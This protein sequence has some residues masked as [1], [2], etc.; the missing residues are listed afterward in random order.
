[1]ADGTLNPEYPINQINQKGVFRQDLGDIKTL[2]ESL[3]H[4]GL[5]TPVVATA[6]GDLICGKRRLA[7]AVKLGWE[8]IPVWIPAKVSAALRLH[9]LVDDDATSKPLNAIEQAGLYAEYEALYAE[10]ARLRREATFFKQGN[11]AA[12]KTGKQAKDNGREESSQPF[13]TMTDE[14]P[15]TREQAAIAVT[16]GKSFQRLDQIRELQAL[17]SDKSQHPEVQHAAVE[18]VCDIEDDGVVNPRWQHVKALQHQ[19]ALEKT[20]VDPGEPEVV[21]EA[22]AQAAQAISLETDPGQA[23]KQARAGVQQVADLHK[24]N[25][26][27]V[28]PVD[29]DAPRRRLVRLLGD[30]LRREHGWWG[31][32]DPVDYAQF[33]D[34]ELLSLLHSYRAG[35]DQFD[36]QVRALRAQASAS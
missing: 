14:V 36:D 8:T 16:G 28:K 21:Q 4:L 29:P 1:M 30:L 19:Y 15:R 12:S 11:T 13:D 34:E 3:E 33:A 18:A 7:A 25:P 17:A 32:N 26:K 2:A 20:A 35:I 9:A 5:L 22:A 10:Q 27:P 6:D 24:T 31:R 23:L